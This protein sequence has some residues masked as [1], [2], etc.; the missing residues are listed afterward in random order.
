MSAPFGHDMVPPS[1]DAFRKKVISFNG[2]KTGPL[3]RYW[4]KSTS[5]PKMIW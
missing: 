4:E 1:I 3:E 5:P 2:S